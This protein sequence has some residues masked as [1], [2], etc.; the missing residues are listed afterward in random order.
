MIYLI[1]IVFCFYVLQ[2]LNALEQKITEMKGGASAPKSTPK[3]VAF[4]TAP[5]VTPSVSIAEQVVPPPPVPTATPQEKSDTEFK[6]GSKVFTGVGAL[7]VLLG[8][9]FFLRYAFEN[10][11]ISQGARVLIGCVLGLVLVFVGHYLK[12]KYANYGFTLVGAGFGVLYLSVYAAYSFYQLIDPVTAF[13]SL[14]VITVASVALSLWYDARP[15]IGYSL[16]GAL[17]MPFL[18]PFSESMHTL[19]I[20]LIVVNASGLFIARFKVWPQLTIGTL[21][22]TSLIYIKWITSSYSEALLIPTLVYCTIIFLTY[23]TTSLLNFIYRDRDYKGIDAIL[24]Y[25]TP[26]TYFILNSTIMKSQ[27]DIAL[28]AL[29][30]GLFN[31]VMCGVIRFAFVEVASLRKF[32]EGIFLMS[33]IFIAIAIG[34][35][36]NGSTLTIVWAMQAAAMVLIGYHMRSSTNTFMGV[37]LSTVVGVKALSVYL[38]YYAA[39]EAIFNERSATFIIV[40]LMYA[41]IWIV[42]HLDG[43]KAESA[44]HKKEEVIVAKNIGIVGALGIIFL[45]INLEAHDFIKNY[46]LYLPLLWFGYALLMTLLSFWTK[47]KLPRYLAYVVIFIGFGIMIINQWSLNVYEHQFLFNVRTA[48]ALACAAV[49]AIILRCMTVQSAQVDEGEKGMKMLLLWAANLAV[50]WAGSLEVLGYFNEQMGIALS[51]TIENSKRVALSVFWLLYA[52]L[53]LGVGISRRSIFARYFS[54][55]LFAVVIFKIFLY[56]TALLSDVYRFVSFIA[57]GIILLIV[58]FAYYRFKDRISEF[59]H[60]EKAE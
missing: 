6:V 2:R 32:S 59:V 20:Y 1:V 25:A 18:L 46:V 48:S 58:G 15:L 56:D 26:I 28:L 37:A 11:L 51:T 17:I 10:N 45:G 21:I 13:I 3:P 35:H 24:L 52:L 14:A 19:F 50:L 9:G 27:D 29:V 34:L 31:L 44:L 33:S 4:E 36:F 53:G 30:I 39:T 54:I 12:K 55:F 5:P 49:A 40:A 22:G 23:F 47:E 16:I 43:S 41:V 42:F 7:A 60:M 8:V 57:L 38:G